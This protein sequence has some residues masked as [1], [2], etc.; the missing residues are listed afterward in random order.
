MNIKLGDVRKNYNTMQNWSVEAA[1]RGSHLVV[2]PELW[3]T[4][5]ALDESKELA[6]VLNSGIF[7]Q[8]TTVAQQNKISIVGSVLEKRGLEVANTAAFFAPNGRVMGVYRKIHLFRLM[9]EDKWLQPGSAPLSMELPWGETALAICYD[10]RFPELFR[11]YAINGAKMIIIPAEWPLI[12]VEHWRALL[13]AR[14]IENQCYIVA[15][16][17]AGETGDTVF[18]GHSMVVDPWGKVMVEA[19]EEPVL[20]TVDIDIDVVDDV[21]QRIP[22]FE[23]RRPELY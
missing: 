6:N 14:A 12:R 10:L 11:H 19:G 2:L 15:C 4:G 7:T 20:L 1:R 5:Y 21:R 16:N 8:V 13:I 9:D 22:V 23:D 3:S 17:A 18:G